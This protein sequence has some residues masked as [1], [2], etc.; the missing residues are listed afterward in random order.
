M[1]IVMTQKPWGYEELL[2]K[3]NRYALK[4]LHI[5]QNDRTSLQFHVK[6]D[7]CMLLESGICE[8]SKLYP[9]GMVSTN[10]LMYTAYHIRPGIQHRLSAVTDCIILEVSTPEL[11][12]VVRVEDDYRRA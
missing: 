10:M 1:M 4:R 2:C 8:I 5:C 11:D 9:A 6:K 7:E 3:T 12:D